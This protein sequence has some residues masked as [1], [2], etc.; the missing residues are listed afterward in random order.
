MCIYI[1]CLYK[2]LVE[3][4]WLKDDYKTLH[5]A[6]LLCKSLKTRLWE[7]SKHVTKQLD[8]IGMIT[9]YIVVLFCFY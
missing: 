5:N 6:V 9:T 4:L 7:D 3:M 2:G 8:R 1:Y